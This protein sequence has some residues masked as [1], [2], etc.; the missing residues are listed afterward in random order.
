MYVQMIQ[1]IVQQKPTQHCEA[2]RL[3]KQ[4]LNRYFFIKDTQMANRHMKRCPTLLIIREVQIK[5]TTYHITLVRMAIIK[6][7]T[8][9]KCQRWFGEKGTLIHCQWECKLVQLLW[10]TVWQFDKI[11][12][13]ELPYDIAIPLLGIYPEKTILQKTSAPQCSLQ[14]CSQQP[15]HEAT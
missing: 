11:L 9:N 12:E 15:R 1:F 5:T 7:S 3:Q 8:N 14:H 6:K 2:I 10:R 4:D 13:I